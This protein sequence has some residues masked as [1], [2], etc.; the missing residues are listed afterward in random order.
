MAYEDV[1]FKGATR[2]AMMLGVPIIPLII[3]VGLHLMVAVWAMVL[4]NI[5]VSFVIVAACVL[6]VFFLR[7]ISSNDEQ[8]LNQYLLRMKSIPGRRNKAYWGAHSVSPCDY[9]RRV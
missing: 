9:R 2:P 4:V 8:R 5:F 1:V 6:N 3:V 7:H